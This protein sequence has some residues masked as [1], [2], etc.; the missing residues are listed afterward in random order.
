MTLAPRH[1][2][3]HSTRMKPFRNPKFSST[4]KVMPQFVFITMVVAM[5]SVSAITYAVVLKQK[6]ADNPAVAA[7]NEA[8]TA[9]THQA[10]PVASHL[11]SK[12]KTH[13]AAEST[14]HSTAPATAPATPPPKASA[15]SPGPSP[16]SSPPPV[17]TQTPLEALT[18]I[19]EQ[20]DDGGQANVTTAA[21]TL[22]GPITNATGRPLV[23]SVDGHTYFA[24]TQE[25]KPDFNQAAAQ[26]AGSMAIVPASGSYSLTSAHL[27][28]SANL[29][30][31]NET[32]V[33][34]SVGG[35]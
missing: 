22:P 21:I 4:P 16:V 28:K 30:D 24:Y 8:N 23:F 20:L 35:D 33:G 13:A 31:E 34:F 10:A 11:S 2:E 6:A 27:D 14:D 1:L 15:A 9:T 17:S 12:S 25:T 19:C 5:I 26:T 3:C 32:A 7:E 18:A 29:V